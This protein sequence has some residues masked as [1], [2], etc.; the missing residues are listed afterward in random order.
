MNRSR[1]L[2]GLTLA[3]VLAQILLPALVMAFLPSA[4]ASGAPASA[5]PFELMRSLRALQ[6]RI[7]SGDA[8]SFLSYPR[9]LAEY[10]ALFAE[11][12]DEVWKDRRN[13]RAA[14]AFAFSG[15]DPQVLER[16]ARLETGPEKTLIKAALAYGGNRN[17][18]AMELL[19]DANP[20]TLDPSIAGHVALVRSELLTKKDPDKALAL[21]AD[22]RLLAPGTMIE[23]SALRRE[24]ALAADRGDAGRFE[25]LMRQYLRRYANSVHMA[26]FRR[27]FATSL[28]TRGMADDVERRSRME[29]AMAVLEPRQREEMYLSV[30]W[31]GIL[32]GRV[33]LVR[34]AAAN[35]TRLA[36]A[37]SP[38]HLR[39]RLF[40]AAVMLVA[41]D[42]FD[43]GLA[44]LRALPADKLDAEEEGLLAAALSVAAEIRRAPRPLP[45]PADQPPGTSPPRIAAVANGAIARVDDLLAGAQK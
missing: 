26:S 10:A 5:Q 38:Q 3:Q 45:G 25:I 14:I 11:T 22:A 23:E 20:R 1:I 4:P 2:P 8:V 41:T 7:A 42:A 40:E 32:A 9:T 17:A 19:A 27:Q 13:V 18:E 35:S 37:D 33:D 36:V 15:G 29:T 12:P 44:E 39:S 34:W 6:D 24:A 30:A 43:K 16:L 21:L 31:E 28:A